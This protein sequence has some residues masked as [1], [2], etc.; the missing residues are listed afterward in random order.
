MQPRA[1]PESI[2]H[3]QSMPR[4]EHSLLHLPKRTQA[5]GDA[6]KETASLQYTN[7]AAEPSPDLNH[8]QCRQPFLV[9][10]EPFQ[11]VRTVKFSEKPCTP[12]MA[13]RQ[14]KMASQSQE[15]KCRHRESYRAALR[16]PVTVQHEKARARMLGVVQEDGEI[17]HCND[18]RPTETGRGAPQCHG[19]KICSKSG[20][21]NQHTS[22]ASGAICEESGEKNTALFWKPGDTNAVL[23]MPDNPGHDG[24]PEFLTHRTTVPFREHCNRT[25]ISLQNGSG[26]NAEGAL[27]STSNPANACVI[28][29]KHHNLACGCSKHPKPCEGPLN[30]PS[31]TGLSPNVPTPV[32]PPKSKR[33]SDGRCSSLSTAVVDTSEKCQL[34]LVDGANVRRDRNDDVYADVPQLHVVKCKK[35]TAFRLVSPQIN[36]MKMAIPGKRYTNLIL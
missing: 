13:R 21:L 19:Q 27:E 3:S 32:S 16:N 17:L 20:M 28:S 4:K 33:E 26:A 12:C 15:M 24:R 10:T 8:S 6:P 29:T 5:N 25:F 36:K 14:G 2:M 31:S 7:V 22:I 35:S 9:T 18:R 30:T 11:C 1:P 23:F 34:V